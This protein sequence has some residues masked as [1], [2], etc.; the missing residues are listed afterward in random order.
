MYVGGFARYFVVAKDMDGIKYSI[1]FANKNGLPFFVLGGGSNILV[2]D[3]GFPG[4]VIKVEISGIKKV[5]EDDE[6]VLFEVGAGKNWDSF[7]EFSVKSHLYGLENLSHIPGTVGASV[8]QNIGAYG[9]EVSSVFESLSAYNTQNGE[10]ENLT[11]DKMDFSYR[12][13]RLNDITK[14]KGKFVILSVKFK[15]Q[16]KGNLKIEYADLKNYFDLKKEKELSLENVREAVI[17]V[18]NKKFPFPDRPENG[19]VGSFWNAKV[20]QEETF[21]QIIEK[22]KGLGYEKKAEEMDGR[23]SV[24]M[25]AQGY[26][27][28]YG[29]L[30]EVLGYKGIVSGG[31]KI[32]ETHAGVINNFTGT[33]TAADVYNLSKEV[34]K[35]VKDEFGVTLKI[36]PELLGDFE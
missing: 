18:R 2:S 22:L 35:K 10:I 9:S 33:G 13:S 3:K 21:N 1:D 7:V 27:V 15:L 17:S 19:T 11:K 20:V 28:P 24:F 12:K 34:M 5:S 30:I 26:K 6:V 16:K 14:D 29:V 25:V 8:V 4:L 36:E 32:L 31:V 23:R